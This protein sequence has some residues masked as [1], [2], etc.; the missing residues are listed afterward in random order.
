[1]RLLNVHTLKFREFFDQEIPPYGILSH[2][3]GEDEISH[4]DFRKGRVPAESASYKKISD[5]CAFVRERTIFDFGP[6]TERR[7][8][9]YERNEA[10]PFSPGGM[11][12]VEGE[13]EALQWVWIDT[14]CINKSSSQE[15]SE[16]INSMFNWYANAEECYVY[17]KDVPPVEQV[18]PHDF[19]RAFDSSDWFLRGW[20]LQEMLAPATV[21]FCSSDWNVFGHI[22]TN[23]GRRQCLE[24]ML[25][26]SALRFELNDRIAQITGVQK[27]Y[28]SGDWPIEGASIAR[29]MSWAAHRKTTRVED[30]AYCLLG[31]F[32]VNM[33]L[34]YGEGRKAFLRLQEEI[35]KRSED[36]SIFAW[37]LTNPDQ[38][39]TG[40]LAPD[41]D[42]FEHSND[43]IKA[44]WRPQAP[45]TITNLGL[46]LVTQTQMAPPDK[47]DNDCEI[48]IVELNCCSIGGISVIPE[49]VEIAL[50]LCNHDDP[51][52]TQRSRCNDLR[53]QGRDLSAVF[54]DEYRED[55]EEQ[56]FHI[57][58]SSHSW[59]ECKA[60]RGFEW[61]VI[62]DI[63]N[64]SAPIPGER[65]LKGL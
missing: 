11:H 26:S 6:F 2:R 20:T 45:F 63:P 15:L 36:Q 46:E 32:G 27:A 65:R 21:I 3:W 18:P 56:K 47:T 29:R 8:E 33:P 7:R 51:P 43:I 60:C 38:E 25:Y 28:L 5:F 30:E 35:I 61:I 9:A 44:N 41:V 22:Q 34:L 13:R 59:V 53:G 39:L 64:P 24:H 50:I 4:K 58:L 19:W 48:H 52:R 1:M 62:N 17:M 49:A 57:K 14:I 42:C 12:S 40:I 23:K 16:A 31:I 54:P 37:S 55:V 10:E